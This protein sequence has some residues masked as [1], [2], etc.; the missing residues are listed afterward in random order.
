VV[1]RPAHWVLCSV[2]K[3]AIVSLDAPCSL[4]YALGMETTPTKDIAVIHTDHYTL[5][6]IPKQSKPTP[7]EEQISIDEFVGVLKDVPL[8]RGKS[9]VEVQHMTGEVWMGKKNRRTQSS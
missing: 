4:P 8:Y 6:K 2:V 5:I 9:S 7:R 1:R 3:V